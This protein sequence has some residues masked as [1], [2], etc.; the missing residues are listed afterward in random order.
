MTPEPNLLTVL[1]R[2]LKLLKLFL[3]K[4][5]LLSPNVYSVIFFLLLLYLNEYKHEVNIPYSITLYK[6]SR[7]WKFKN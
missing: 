5:T 6:Y 2:F 4:L 3:L 1:P 7:N